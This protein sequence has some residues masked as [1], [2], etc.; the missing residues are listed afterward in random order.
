MKIA[1]SWWTTNQ[2][3]R[4]VSSKWTKKVRAQE[5]QSPVLIR[6]KFEQVMGIANKD[7]LIKTSYTMPIKWS[8][9]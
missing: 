7:L 5:Y 2:R 4:N 8:K 1:C 6:L 3:S 9:T